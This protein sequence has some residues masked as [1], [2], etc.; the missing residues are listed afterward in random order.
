MLSC[1]RHDNK[2][3]IKRKARNNDIVVFGGSLT[4]VIVGSGEPPTLLHVSS[5]FFSSVDTTIL[6]G[7]TSG[8]WGG[9]STVK[10]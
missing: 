1:G 8:G 6:P 10:L 9:V 5:C 3:D 4:Y 2:M 7:A